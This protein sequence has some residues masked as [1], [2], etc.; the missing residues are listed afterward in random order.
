MDSA[1]AVKVLRKRCDD[2]EEELDAATSAKEELESEVARL[3]EQVPINGQGS[4]HDLET[5]CAQLQQ[6]LEELTASHKHEKENAETIASKM[7]DCET[8]HER[9]TTE[10]GRERE[11]VEAFNKEQEKGQQQHAAVVQELDELKRSSTA[12]KDALVEMQKTYRSLLKAH[13]DME[14]AYHE[15]VNAQTEIEELKELKQASEA[16]KTALAELQAK[17]D[18]LKNR[19]Q[20]CSQNVRTC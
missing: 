8:Q 6:Q 15:T 17:H 16:D 12:D 14:E 2:L 4:S 9:L 19:S 7:L 10:L 18:D 11:K 13:Q 5:K 20:K 1:Q 3:K